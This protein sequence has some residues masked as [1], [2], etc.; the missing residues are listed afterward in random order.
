[1]KFVHMNLGVKC[2]LTKETHRL[3]KEYTAKSLL[4]FDIEQ[5]M[6]TLNR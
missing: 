1:M 6:D 2:L 3:I 5:V 4:I